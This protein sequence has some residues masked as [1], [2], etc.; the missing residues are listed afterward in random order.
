MPCDLKVTP[1]D[2]FRMSTTT[3]N[4]FDVASLT[5]LHWVGIVAAFVTAAIHLALGLLNVGSPM[6]Q[7]FVVAGVGFLAGIATVVAD[8]R[9]RLVYLLG[10]PFT[11]GQ[12]VIWY[13]ANAPEF[14]PLGIA[15]K[16]VQVVLIVVI[17]LLYRRES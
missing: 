16:V 7:S 9:R 10:I 14:G 15:D 1:A 11:G 5:P 8:Y 12:I 4:R 2:S 3:A 13:V 6:G 17:V